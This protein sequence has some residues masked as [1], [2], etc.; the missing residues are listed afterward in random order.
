MCRHLRNSICEN[1]IRHAK[2][3]TLIYIGKFTQLYRILFLDATT[4][5]WAITDLRT[6]GFVYATAGADA[7][8]GPR[9]R[10][11]LVTFYP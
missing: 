6:L 1:P 2:S 7:R 11:F 4:D 9:T 8:L 5:L 3:V 10:M